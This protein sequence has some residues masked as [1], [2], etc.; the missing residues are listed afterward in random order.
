[1]VT[2]IEPSFTTK[3][4]NNALKKGG[5]ISFKSGEYNLT[6]PLVLCSQSY[7]DAHDAKFIRAHKGR[8]LQLA[9]LPT[10]TW[11]GGTND[12]FWQGGTFVADSR[13]ENAN[14]ISLFHGY[15]IHIT[16]V[17]VLGCRGMHSIEVNA[18]REVFIQS[19]TI[20][21]QSSKKGEN[22]R[23]AIQIDFANYDGLKVKGATPTSP[24]YDGTHCDSVYIENCVIGA[25]PNG[26][27][28]HTVSND[29]MHYH[30]NIHISNCNIVT[31]RNAI[32]LYGF[33]TC[34]I[35]NTTGKIVIGKKSTAHLLT[36]GK[37][38]RKTPKIC[39]NIRV[40]TINIE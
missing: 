28:T 12:V 25:C 35:Q 2:I 23:E 36:G 37:V 34:R 38:E 20:E 21:R 17:T 39:K 32:Q 15:D 18:C 19:C 3:Q 16:G 40:G 31:T 24:C 5:N 4:I 8:M 10:T 26:I 30:R 7:I 9:V 29:D 14:V 33:D 22:F 27:G 6:E 1:M 11:Y 13:T